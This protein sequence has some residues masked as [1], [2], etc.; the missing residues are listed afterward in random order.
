MSKIVFATPFAT[1]A[2][3]PAGSVQ[4]KDVTFNHP[5]YG[6]MRLIGV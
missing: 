3:L 6:V 1:I 2:L 5:K 4:A